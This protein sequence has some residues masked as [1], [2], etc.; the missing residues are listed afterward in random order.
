MRNVKKLVSLLLALIMVSSVLFDANIAIAANDGSTQDE[1]TNLAALVEG[2]IPTPGFV[3]E[4]TYM[5]MLA[6]Y[7][8]QGL[9]PTTDI[10]ISINIEDVRSS[11]VSQ[12]H[13]EH[14][15]SGREGP[16]I[17]W[18]SFKEYLEWE[19]YAPESGL[20]EIYIE[21][22]AMPGSG[23]LIQRAIAINGEVLFREAHNIGFSRTWREEGETRFNNVG[24]EVWARQ[25]EDFIWSK[26][27]VWD[28]MGSH[29][30][31]L[32]FY[33]PQ[34]INTIKLL[35]V[36]Q[37]MAIGSITVQSPTVVPSYAEYLRALQER[38]VPHGTEIIRFEAQETYFRNDPTIRR[39]SSNDPASSP[40]APG[41]RLLNIMGA[42]RWRRGN[43]SI[44]WRFYVPEAGLYQINMRTNQG[45]E[46][47]LPAFRQIKINGEIPFEEMRAY[48]FPFNRNWH[49]TTLSDAYGTPF[50]FYLNQG[51]NEITMTVKLG[52]AYEVI[53][54]SMEDIMFLSELYRRIV[55][56]TGP[57]PDPNFEYDLDRN[58]PGLVDD[59][60]RLADRM[61][62]SAQTLIDIS[63]R[64]PSMANGFLQNRD[65]F[66]R[67]ANNPDL[68]PRALSD[69]E[70][71]QIG[72]GSYIIALQSAPLAF[73]FFIVSP[74]GAEIE[75]REQSRF[76]ERLWFT[77]VNFINSF[78]RDFNSVGNVFDEE[79]TEL[80]VINVWIAR[81]REWAEILKEMA[82]EDF[83]P[84]TGIAINMN[85]LPAG[86][87]GAGSI[88]TL[89]LAI[90]SDRAPDVA[91]AVTPTSPVEFAFRDAA[92]DLTQFHNF[93]EV[94]SRFHD[95]LFVPLYHQGGI[96][97]LP[98]T[99]NFTVMFYRADILQ[100]IGAELPNTWHELRRFTLPTLYQNMMN[101][102]MPFSVSG[103]TGGGGGLP[104]FLF[105]HGAEYYRDGGRASGLDSAEAFA[106]FREWT[107]LYTHFGIPT[108][109]HFFTRFRAGDIPI[110]IGGYSHYM[111]ISTSA[112]EL[113]GRWGIAPVPG[114]L[115]EDGTIDRSVG[116]MAGEM[117]MI[118][119]QSQNKDAAWQFLDWW[120]SE[121]IQIRFGR[122]L[123]ALLGVEARWNTANINAF[124]SLPWR[125]DHLEVIQYQL[126]QAN[127]EPVVLGGYF[128]GRHINNAWN[129]IVLQGA[130]VRDSLEQAVFDINR[131][132]RRRQE[133]YGFIVAD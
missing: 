87:M 79:D 14:N 88:N 82:D 51:Y 110:G 75:M 54:R 103:S 23:S 11:D 44:T 101:F 22:L 108:E 33:F 107:E 19:F 93:E 111:Q 98:E 20:Y 83:T 15:L 67:M 24:D 34:G 55:M 16:A 73:D 109:T 10:S 9:L 35:Y 104:M 47:G 131:E 38:G 85:V 43:Q 61:E 128:T 114:I 78:T 6:I 74:P 121:E 89:M 63:G 65:M 57:T 2:L 52:P 100:E 99:M 133:E 117:A 58:I 70:N 18:P 29:A 92:A 27:A 132:L 56:I 37:P 71:A 32:R 123:E 94:A 25:I 129:R 48:R 50:L 1:P 68:I 80:Q 40:A 96:F 36:D 3:R 60:L 12:L 49:R 53:N 90:A 30:W 97:G 42:R 31:P 17:V 8:E 124:N 102:N 72:I 126:A 5:D 62:E 125:R 112:P 130:P 120:T 28:S 86:Q 21:Y 66:R 64:V 7:E 81:G 77:F 46:A 106:A 105:Q 113:F 116:T 76:W 13:I 122:E 45:Y 59:L 4:L 119:Q 69:F 95:S 84:R 39:E 26:T 41:N 127:E 115:R 91:L 118:T